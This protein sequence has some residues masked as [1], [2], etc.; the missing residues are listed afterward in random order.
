[1]EETGTVISSKAD[2]VT[3][4]FERTDACKKCGACTFGEDGEMLMN[5]R[6]ETGAAVG[7]LV[8]VQLS[9]KRLLLASLLAYGLPLAGLIGG[10]VLGYYILADILRTDVALTAAAAGIVLMLAC[11]V[12][13]RVT[14]GAR[15]RNGRFLPKAI[16]KTPDGQKK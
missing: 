4:R 7:D 9:E 12:I 10:L 14:E 6:N 2:E 13:L 11:F 5:M 8:T 1:M 16:R 3:V 15:R